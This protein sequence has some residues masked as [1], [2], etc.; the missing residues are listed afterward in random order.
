[1]SEEITRTPLPHPEV[2]RHSMGRL[3][4]ELGWA[5]D[6]EEAEQL[7]SALF[8]DLLREIHRED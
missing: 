7:A 8:P 6:L 5:E 4:F 1:M 3:L 2:T